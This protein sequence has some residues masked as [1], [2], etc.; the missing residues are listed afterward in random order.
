VACTLIFFV[1]R[2]SYK[3]KMARIALTT[4]VNAVRIALMEDIES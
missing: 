3:P 4:A 2:S 1:T